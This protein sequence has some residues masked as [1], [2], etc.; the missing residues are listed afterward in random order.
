MLLLNSDIKYLF[1]ISFSFLQNTESA[2]SNCKMMTSEKVYL[3]TETFLTIYKN[4]RP[5]YMSLKGIIDPFILVKME[6]N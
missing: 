4:V 1:S 3:K 5:R 6:Y 2:S